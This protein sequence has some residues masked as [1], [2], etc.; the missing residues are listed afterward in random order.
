MCFQPC[1]FV[2]GVKRELSK[3]EKLEGKER[4]RSRKTLPRKERDGE[5]EEGGEGD[6]GGSYKNSGRT[7]PWCRN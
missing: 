5:E 2:G 7:Y 6:T 4:E 1:V 3:E